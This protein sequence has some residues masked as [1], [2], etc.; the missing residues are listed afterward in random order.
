MSDP[1]SVPLVPAE[2]Q[3]CPPDPSGV[4]ERM[5]SDQVPCVAHVAPRTG[6]AAPR[7]ASV[8]A[9]GRTSRS[10]LPFSRWRRSPKGVVT[11]SAIVPGTRA[12]SRRATMAFGRVRLF[13]GYQRTTHA[14]VDRPT[15]SMSASGTT[16][17]SAFCAYDG[18]I[19]VTTAR[20]CA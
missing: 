18:S 17:Q 6:A 12:A 4:H 20:A 19:R 13:T 15:A 2:P 3:A 5:R 9:G 14:R 7:A 11:S 10:P 8:P 1:R 16:V